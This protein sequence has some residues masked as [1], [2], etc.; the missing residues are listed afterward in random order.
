MIVCE[1]GLNHLGDLEY[2][3]YYLERIV[4]SRTDAITF[5]VRE[6]EFYNNQKFSKFI[7]PD[8][9]YVNSKSIL[10]KNNIKFGIA[11]ADINKIDFF[12][13]IDV[14]FYK[15][16]SKDFRNIELISELVKT[17]KKIYLST[18]TASLEDITNIVNVFKNYKEKLILIHTQLSYNIDD[19]N[20]Q[21]IAEMQKTFKIPI[22]YGSHSKNKNVI[23]LSLA[24]NPSDIFFYVHG[25]KKKVHPD[26]Y[27]AIN[28][29]N[30]P[31]F[32][33]EINELKKALGNGLKENIGDSIRNP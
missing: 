6:K 19:V 25:N 29:T 20:L 13:K 9:F 32:V 31:E 17:K 28:L 4:K 11:I 24:F 21:A 16:L 12:K 7:L 10:K 14:D 5:Q 15:I 33:S 23:F 8:E 18:G 2:A 1:V 26:E 22:A 3:N 30:L 27:Y